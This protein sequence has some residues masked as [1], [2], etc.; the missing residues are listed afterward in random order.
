MVGDLPEKPV[1]CMGLQF[2]NPIGLAAGMDKN[3]ACVDGFASLG[4]GFIEVGT[5]TPRSQPGNPKPRLF[6]LP[7]HEAIIN[8]MGF[9]NHGVEELL[10]NVAHVHFQGPLGINIGKNFDTPLEEAAEDYRACLEAV[11]SRADYIAV[12]ISSPNTKNLRELQKGDAFGSLLKEVAETRTRLAEEQGVRKPIAVKIAPDM[13]EDQIRFMADALVEAGMDAVIATNTTL[14]HSVV[15][16]HAYAEEAGGLSGAP[17]RERS[18]QV[19]RS[20]SGHLEGTL[21]IIGVGGIFT[22]SDAKEKLD[23]GATLLQLYT[24][25]I[26]QGPGVV[27]EILKGI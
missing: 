10:Q 16:G 15:Q 13:D 8:R 11:Y 17:V 22:A 1:T 20:L 6:R 5:V 9:N 3:G 24:G 2:R 4:F 19:I 12:N 21:P 27:S 14:D 18:T 23:A 25:L 26:Y 7:Q